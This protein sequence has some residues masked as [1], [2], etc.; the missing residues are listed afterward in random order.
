[1]GQDLSALSKLMDYHHSRVIKIQTRKGQDKMT[2]DLFGEF[3]PPKTLEEEYQDYINSAEWKRLRTMKL[4][5]VG[6]I[7]EMC[8]R[9]KWSVRLEVHHL[10]YKNFRREKLEDLQVLCVECHPKGDKKRVEQREGSSLVRGFEN[11]MDHGKKGNWRKLSDKLLQVEW[12]KFVTKMGY[13]DAPYMRS[14]Q[15]HK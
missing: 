7:C 9:S 1:M 11:W 15:W 6:Y 8:K 12:R 2:F 13:K 3:T 5:Q 14:S 4:E 10:N